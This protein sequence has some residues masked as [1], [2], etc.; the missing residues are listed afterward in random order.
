MVMALLAAMLLVQ[1][2]ETMS[3]L[4]DPLYA[5]KLSREARVAADAELARAHAAYTARPSGVPEILALA[6][7]HLALGRVGDAL[8]LLTQGLETN[9]DAPELLLERGRGY[10]LIRKFD[11]AAR[12]LGK[13]AAKLPEARCSLALAQYLAADYA[14]A[15]VSY[16]GCQEPGVFAY[17]AER[18]AGGTTSE[19]PVPDGAAPA[20]SPVIRFPGTVAQS[21][22]AAPEPLSATY[23]SA[24]EALLEGRSDEARE[25]LKKLVERNRGEWMQPAY[26]AAEADYAKL[27]QHKTKR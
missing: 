27:A 26:I 10:I 23:L 16:K 12:D 13:A 15:R 17:L 6:R 20:S 18:R 3:L 4:G 24:I 9:P 14:R 11:V 19:R 21:K 2:P 25:R 8:I 22:D 1:Q 7:A 5:P